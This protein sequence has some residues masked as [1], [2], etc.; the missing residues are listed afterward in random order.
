MFD[1]NYGAALWILGASCFL[2]AGILAGQDPR[3]NWIKPVV[4]LFLFGAILCAFA[5]GLTL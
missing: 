3:G 2:L 4:G 5:A 1:F